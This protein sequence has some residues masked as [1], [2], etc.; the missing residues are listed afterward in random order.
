M[1]GKKSIMG[2]PGEAWSM[3][4][5]GGRGLGVAGHQRF[6]AHSTLRDAVWHP[7]IPLSC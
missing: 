1:E 5:D 2:G 6:T 3:K 4:G 7:A